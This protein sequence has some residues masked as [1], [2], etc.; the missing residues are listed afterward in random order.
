MYSYKRPHVSRNESNKYAFC[1]MK[2]RDNYKERIIELCT[3]THSFSKE[4]FIETLLAVSKQLPP[5]P[6]ELF[7]K[8]PRIVIETAPN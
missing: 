6:D 4:D 2:L 3:E 7:G 5:F 8:Q 1:G